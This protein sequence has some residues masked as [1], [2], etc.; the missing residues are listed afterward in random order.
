VSAILRIQFNS[1]QLAWFCNPIQSNSFI[2]S[3]VLALIPAYFS[4]CCSDGQRIL[5]IANNVFVGIYGVE[6]VRVCLFDALALIAWPT[7]VG[8]ALM[9]IS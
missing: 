9:R 7:C 2:L 1:A 5:N 3:A 8:V 4:V 6:M